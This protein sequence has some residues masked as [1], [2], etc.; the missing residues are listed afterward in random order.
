MDNYKLR[1]SL[2]TISNGFFWMTIQITN[3]LTKNQVNQLLNVR[4][5]RDFQRE[6]FDIY[7]ESEI[8]VFDSILGTSI[9]AHFCRGENRYQGIQQNYLLPLP[10]YIFTK[11]FRYLKWRNPEPYKAILGVG[12]PL[13][14]PYPY[15]LYR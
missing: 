5:S 15:C 11:H 3:R 9:K 8:S 14:K 2:L 6:D 1:L 4:P 12:F 7:T 13:H 10:S